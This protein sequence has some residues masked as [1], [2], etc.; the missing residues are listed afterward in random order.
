MSQ[1]NFNRRQFIRGASAALALASLQANG[2]GFWVSPSAKP[3]R[4]ALIG[5]GWYG[6]SDLFRLIQVT[7]VEVVGL[8]DPDKHQL[9][10][11]AEMVSQRQSNKKSPATYGDYRKLL[12]EQKPEIVLIGSPDHWHA[13]QAIDSIKSGAHVYVQK[14]ISVDVMEGEAMVAAARKYNRV[15][16]VGTQRKST[17]HLIDAKKNIVDAG[18]L[19]KISHVEMCCYYHM[20]NNGNPPVQ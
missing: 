16:Q 12:A 8:C 9:E 13:L 14:P 2:M 15:V 1:H 17:P 7:P 19:G 18:L 20:R 10:K 4:V 3:R 6:K 11:A 5:T